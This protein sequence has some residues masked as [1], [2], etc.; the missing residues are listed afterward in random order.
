MRKI[1]K[2]IFVC[3]FCTTSL[4][5]ISQGNEVS[6]FYFSEPQP[7]SS[8]E[9]KEFDS[10]HFGVYRLE[11]QKHTKLVIENDSILA[12]YLIAFEMTMHEIDT[13]KTFYIKD[14]LLYGVTPVGLHYIN[15]N[16]TLLV[17]LNQED[18]YCSTQKN[19]IKRKGDTYY[20]N[21]K[22]A[23]GK[24]R[25]IIIEISSKGIE[26]FDLD[27]SLSEKEV[28]KITKDTDFIGDMLTY[29]ASP[30]DKQ[31]FT[32]AKS[33]GYRSEPVIYKKD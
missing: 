6:S 33:K 27:H 2:I 24:W 9:I 3:A 11:G 31:F 8:P 1:V 30:N 28:S 19:V 25:T 20:L 4:T 16:D 10:T 29:V 22:E 12:K 21:R 17:A 26:I 13:S 14:E 18:L 23:E 7:V 32:L 5:G 15:N